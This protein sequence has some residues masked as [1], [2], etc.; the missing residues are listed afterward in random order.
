MS[1][2]HHTK[3]N[4]QWAWIYLSIISFI[5]TNRNN[6]NLVFSLRM[7]ENDYSNKTINNKNMK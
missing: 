7:L 6:D 3:K 5:V 4:I 1:Y 2:K